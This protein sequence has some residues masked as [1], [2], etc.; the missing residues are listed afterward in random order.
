MRNII[1]MK[2]DWDP[3]SHFEKIMLNQIEEMERLE[4]ADENLRQDNNETNNQTYM[5]NNAMDGATEELKVEE[6]NSKD[7]SAIMPNENFQTGISQ[8]IINNENDLVYYYE[9]V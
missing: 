3:V 4:F 8:P 2:M 7:I 1:K 9:L 6:M 5:T